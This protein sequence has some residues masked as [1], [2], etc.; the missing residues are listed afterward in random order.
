MPPIKKQTD[1][2]HHKG[3]F[4]SLDEVSS[5]TDYNAKENLTFS[6][7]CLLKRNYVIFFFIT[8]S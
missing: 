7:E 1:L 2:N 8:L 5:C 3:V 4:D 6:M